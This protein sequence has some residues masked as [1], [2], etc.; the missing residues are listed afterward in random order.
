M[1]IDLNMVCS[2]QNEATTEQKLEEVGKVAAKYE[3]YGKARDLVATEAYHI[4]DIFK[5]Y[6]LD[7]LIRLSKPNPLPRPYYVVLTMGELTLEHI[8]PIISDLVGLS[9]IN[10]DQISDIRESM[11]H[12][13][14]RIAQL[15]ATVAQQ[16]DR[17][18]QLE[19]TVIQQRDAII[20]IL[21]RL[22]AAEQSLQP[23]PTT[24]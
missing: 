8:A 14:A 3:K 12:R 23:A 18:A 17:I 15:E 2:P 11:N 22:E 13:D 16:A 7:Q 1:A 4:M 10:G 24:Q 5:L 21:A 9:Y 6:M 20:G 19:D